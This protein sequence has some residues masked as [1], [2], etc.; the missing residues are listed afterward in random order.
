MEYKVRIDPT[1]FQIRNRNSQPDV[2]KEDCIFGEDDVIRFI[3]DR[4][5]QAGL[6]I[7]MIWQDHYT[8]IEY[9]G[10]QEYISIGA[11]S[12][13]TPEQ[14]VIDG[15][16]ELSYALNDFEGIESFV[17]YLNGGHFL[18]LKE[19]DDESKGDPEE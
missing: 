17:S 5:N 15:M 12:L 8:G 4:M 13:S 19:A 14:A 18:H 11:A 9:R 7:S 10:R 3:I 2:A 6:K 16:H 1:E